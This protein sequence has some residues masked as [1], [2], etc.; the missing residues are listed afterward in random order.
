MNLVLGIDFC[1]TYFVKIIFVS[2]RAKSFGMKSSK[3]YFF[4]FKDTH[5]SYYKQQT[6]SMGPPIAKYNL[7]GILFYNFCKLTLTKKLEN[8]KNQKYQNCIFNSKSAIVKQ[9]SK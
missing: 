4:Q 7:K 6:E 3:G 5:I 8:A 2:F 9:C 1:K